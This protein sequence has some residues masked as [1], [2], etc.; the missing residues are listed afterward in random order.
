VGLPNRVWTGVTGWRE[1]INR[2]ADSEVVLPRGTEP[3]VAV[4]V[5]TASEDIDRAVPVG[6]RLAA[7]WS[8]RLILVAA[9]VCGLLYLAGYLSEVVIPV[10]VAILLAAMLSPVSNR[11]RAWGWNAGAA[12]AVTLLGGLVL[13]AGALTLITTQIVAQAA[14]LSGNVTTGFNDLLATLQN[15]RLPI[16]ASYFDATAW[17]ER[18][19]TFLT[20][21]RST[22]ASYAAEVGSQVGHFVAGLAITL[23]SLFYFLYDGRGIFGAMLRFFPRESRSRVDHAASNGWRA[24]SGYVRATILVAVSDG[25]FVLVGAL[26]I[27]VPVAPALAAL[28]FIGAFVPLVG[29]FVSGTVAVLVALV[30]LGWVQ[31]LFM[32]GVIILVLEV[33]GHL[34]QPLLLGRAVKLHPLAVLLAIASGIV[35]AG[36]IG[37]L[38][39]VPLL[40]F[41]KSF[42]EYLRGHK[43]PQTDTSPTPLGDEPDAGAAVPEREPAA[44]DHVDDREP[45]G[46]DPVPVPDRGRPG[47]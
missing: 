17:G 36:I 27:G 32:L 4:P 30:A 7:S 42:V 20:E 39:A 34:L 16:N 18:I 14:D 33:E 40:A 46:T 25:I 41:S 47:I 1:A 37:A 12:A 28:V 23:F 45:A 44:A 6:L 11:L 21:S 43:I 35:I 24:L 29:A 13:I 22:I 2:R 19:Q 10:A 31:A 8:W 9:L 5:L 3:S 38:L 15:S 26:V